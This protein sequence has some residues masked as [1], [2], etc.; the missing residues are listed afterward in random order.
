MKKLFT[1]FFALLFCAMVAPAQLTLDSC[2]AMAERNYPLIH[3]YGL[4]ERSQALDLSDINKG[5]LP[6]FELYGQATV[7]N[8]VP[9]FPAALEDMLAQMGRD[10]RGLGKEQYKIGLDLNQTVWDGGASKNR[11]RIVKA[12]SEQNR[13]ALDVELYAIRERVENLFF[14]I[15]LLD[16][17]I[18]SAEENLDLLGANLRRIKAMVSGGTAMQADAD[19]VEAQVLGTRQ[20]I[21][22]AK[23]ARKGYA[24]ALGIFIG[25]SIG[26][27]T[28]VMP[29]AVRP[30]SSDDSARPEL[31]LFDARIKAN[32]A[33][34]RSVDVATMPKIGLFA[35]AYYGYPGFNYFESMMNRDLSFNVL[36]GVKI[37]WSIDA[38]YTRSNSRR[39][40]DLADES[41][42]ADR[43]TFLFNNGLA[44]ATQ[45]KVIDGLED[46][47]T[48]DSRIVELRAKVR[49]AA[50]SQLDNGIIDATA[51]L[52]KITDEKVARLNAAYHRIQYVQA[53]YKLKYTLNR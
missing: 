14:G 34:R 27:R 7:Q 12:D 19:M 45:T 17:Q 46:V 49:R 53:V 23:A 4:V 26:E 40:L 9:T 6:R 21:S 51:L 30:I 10:I 38:F 15:L 37:S 41:V 36:A 47:M 8:V 13:A 31:R 42:A 2:L 48:D 24:D 3:K 43:E 28:L 16:S 35:Q 5:W 20:Q 44:A 39:K 18:E 50:E 25:E 11:R 52:T 22:E 1:S 32:D 33:R 29:K